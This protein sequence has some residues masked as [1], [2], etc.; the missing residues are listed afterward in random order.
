VLVAPSGRRYVRSD[1]LLWSDGLA[2]RVRAEEPALTELG[3]VLVADLLCEEFANVV[4]RAYARPQGPTWAT[5]LAG[6]P[7]TLVFELSSRFADGA[8]LLTNR[9]PQ[10]K[11]DSAKRS[12]R[13]GFPDADA[14]TLLARHEARLAELEATHGSSLRTVPSAR[15]LAESVEAALVQQLG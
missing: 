2:N 13:Q 12:Y 14:S 8:S 1:V 10:A 15:G 3:F 11:D 5:F 7:S 9:S 6:A 4:V